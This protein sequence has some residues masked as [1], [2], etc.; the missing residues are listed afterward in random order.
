MCTGV[1]VDPELLEFDVTP[2]DQFFLLATDGLWDVFTNDEAVQFIHKRLLVGETL[3]QVSR[4][5]V[6]EAYKKLST[7]NITAMLVLLQ[8]QPETEKSHLNRH[9]TEL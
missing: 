8:L 4:A 6:Q 1:I 5:I 9:A 2:Q 3:E 7:D